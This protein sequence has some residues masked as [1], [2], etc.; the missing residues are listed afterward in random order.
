[1]IQ[2]QA[3]AFSPAPAAKQQAAGDQSAQIAPSPEVVEVESAA[4]QA[5][6]QNKNRDAG[7][8]QDSPPVR[9]P[10]TEEYALAR[11]GKAKPAVTPEYAGLGTKGG[12]LP[13]A[14]AGTIPTSAPLPTWSISSN[15]ALQRSYDQGAT[16][17]LV[18]V[19]TTLG[20]FDALSVQR[21]AKSSRGDSKDGQ[22]Q[23]LKRDSASPTF[24]AVAANAADVWAGGSRGTL[25]HSLDAG[26]HWTR[27][28]PALA[29]AVL[30]GDV[31]S[32]EFVDA[33]HGRV[34]TSTAENWITSDGGQTWRKQ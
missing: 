3:P 19:N 18:D 15:G 6:T 30:T 34:S 29:G 12:P 11:V 14:M 25:Y 32:L 8:V 27:V 4:A 22:T 21:T 5:D 9:Q 33:Q 1:V 10:A 31:V 26:D 24:R 23:A 13:S 28:L 2:N 7:K 17:Q 20:A 16:W